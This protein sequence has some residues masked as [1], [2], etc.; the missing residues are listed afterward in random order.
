LDILSD[1][2]AWGKEKV[3]PGRL[4]TDPGMSVLTWVVKSGLQPFFW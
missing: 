3:H 2:S 1:S 4:I